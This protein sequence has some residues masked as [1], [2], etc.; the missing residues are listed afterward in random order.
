MSA[1]PV[2]VSP[3]KRIASERERSLRLPRQLYRLRAL[4]LGVG[5]FAVA[6]VFYENRAPWPAWALLVFHVLLWPHIAWLHARRSADPHLAE[7]T[8]LTVDSAFGG[9]YVALMH[10]NLLPSVLI[11]AMAAACA[12]TMIFTRAAFEPHTSMRVVVASLPLLVAYPLAVAFTSYR[13][14]RLARERNK[15][16]EQTAALREQLAHIARV[17]TLGEWRPAWRTS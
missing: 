8:N 10:F 2:P 4:G 16:I 17:G 7:R 5:A 6:V 11:A 3:D 1:G 15:A 12:V 13:S 14:G 9:I